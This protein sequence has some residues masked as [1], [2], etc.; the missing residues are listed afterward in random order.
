MPLAGIVAAS[1]HDMIDGSKPAATAACNTVRRFRKALSGVI[2]DGLIST[3]NR[4]RM[5]FTYI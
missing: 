1:P 2:S 5:I 3:S 4:L